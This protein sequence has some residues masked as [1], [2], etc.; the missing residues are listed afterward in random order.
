MAEYTSEEKYIIDES[1]ELSMGEVPGWGQKILKV[2]PAFRNK[3]YQLYFAGQLVS[4]IGTWLQIVAQ[5][6][7]VLELTNSAF[8]IGLVA[9]ISTFPTLLFS[10]FGGVIVDRFSKQKIIFFTQFASMVLAFVLGILTVLKIVNVWEIMVLSFLLGVVNAIDMPA[11]QAFTV[12]M[13]GK[14]DMASAIALNSG[15][16]NSARVIGPSIAGFLIAFWGAGGAFL[17]NGISYVAVI[18]ALFYIKPRGAAI[19][20][21]HP[22]PIKAIKEGVVYSFSHPM[23]RMLLILTGVVSVFGW[24][25]TTILPII[26]KQTFHMGP[27]GL[28][29]LYSISGLGALLATFLVSAFSNKVSSLKFILGGNAIFAISM[30]LFT[31]SQS[32]ATAAPILFIAG[33][34]LL[35]Q[36]STINT[37]IQHLVEDKY[38]GRV[39]SIYTLMFVGLFP[40][41]NFEIGFLTEHFGANFAIRFGAVVVFLFGILIYFFRDRIYKELR[42]ES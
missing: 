34:G 8:L 41:G 20:R 5:G 19:P 32:F 14:E 27:E 39:M 12:E 13:V 24:S 33:I 2:F 26:T 42:F 16:F 7:L 10:L 4:L 9:A 18:V 1:G 40:L 11:R 3:N 37:T 17:A 21:T 36:F 25:Y 31:F 30:F 23:I 6:W 38:R 29:Y 35:A 22:H 15:I 28:G